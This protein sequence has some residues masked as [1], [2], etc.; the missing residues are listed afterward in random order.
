M[1]AKRKKY[2]DAQMIDESL[3]GTSVQF[4]LSH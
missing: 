2:L 3:A 4:F 1:P